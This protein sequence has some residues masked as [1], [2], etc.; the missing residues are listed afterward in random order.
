MLL[1]PGDRG[2]GQPIG[3]LTVPDRF[4]DG[5][6]QRDRLGGVHSD[7]Y[8]SRQVVSSKGVLLTAGDCQ[9]AGT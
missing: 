5:I 4:L 7:G 6:G 2:R 9:H 1:Q 3:V 8:G